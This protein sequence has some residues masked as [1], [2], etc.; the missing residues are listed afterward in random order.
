MDQKNKLVIVLIGGLVIIGMAVFVNKSVKKNV[1]SNQ[2]PEQQTQAAL[3]KQYNWSPH[4][5]TFAYPKEYFII[6]QGNVLVVSQFE[7]LPDSDVSAFFTR[8][9]FTENRTLD[10][11]LASN[12]RTQKLEKIVSETTEVINGR[13]FTKLV[14]LDGFTSKEETYYLIATKNGILEY[15]VGSN[16]Q[17]VAQNILSSLVF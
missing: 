7:T 16:G 3:T 15:K 9:S 11:V 17:E 12:H 8:I 6:D 10:E 1:Q 14:V 13:T 2:L 4:S 5:V